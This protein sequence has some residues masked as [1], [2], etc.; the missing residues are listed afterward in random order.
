MDTLNALRKYKKF[1]SSVEDVKDAVRLEA[2]LLHI[3]KTFDEEA[4]EIKRQVHPGLY[5]DKV[6]E[7]GEGVLKELESGCG[8]LLRTIGCRW[9]T[10]QKRLERESGLSPATDAPATM[11]DNWLVDR[12]A[13]M[14]PRERL[15]TIQRAV[16]TE[17]AP[18]LRA[19]L[20]APP[21]LNLFPDARPLE[22][23]RQAWYAKRV[24]ELSQ[25]YKSLALAYKTEKMNLETARR[26][27]RQI[28]GI[29]QSIRD[30]LE[31]S[32]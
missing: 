21:A 7:R 16:E 18:T 12:L 20:H 15:L 10:C 28:A 23:C 14:S 2:G 32:T 27:I 24:P 26:C 19:A 4:A 13:A 1:S 9:A 6:K 29:D 17:D 22:E 30:R 11:R 3:I 5:A 8:G 25:E 31:Q